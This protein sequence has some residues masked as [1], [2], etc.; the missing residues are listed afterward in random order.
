MKPA[1][2]SGNAAPRSAAARWPGRWSPRSSTFTPSTTVAPAPSASGPGRREQRVL[3]P[4]AAVA[5]VAGVGGVVELVGLTS[6]QRMPH[7]PPGRRTRS[8][9]L[10]RQR[11]RHRGDGERPLG[12][13]GV[14]GDPR[15]ERRVGAAGERDHHRAELAQPVAQRLEVERRRQAS[16]TSMR[17]RLLP[18]PFDSVFT[19]RMRPTSP[20]ERTW[21]PPSACLSRPD[22]VDHPDLGAPT[23]GSGSP[24]CG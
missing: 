21:V 18:L 13:E 1:S 2:T 19:T 12:A 17:M 16:T 6:C 5:V 15:E 11:R 4:V 8:R 24:S 10:G 3:A 14:V 7:A 20:V 9:S 22:D 23:R